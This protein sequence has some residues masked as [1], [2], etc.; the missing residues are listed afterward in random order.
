M[1]ATAVLSAQYAGTLE[2]LDST[3]VDARATQPAPTLTA[4]LREI[5]LAADASTSPTARLRLRDRWWDYALS[6]S[7]SFGVTDVELGAGAQP[8]VSNAGTATIA[9]HDRVV[10]VTV[11]ESASYGLENLAYLYAATGQGLAGGT[12]QSMGG[13][14]PG[15]PATMVPGQP[16][17]ATAAG[18]PATAAAMSAATATSATPLKLFPFGS[19]NTN[20][21]V[22]VR[23]TR[24]VTLSL[25]GGYSLAGSLTTNPQAEVA[26]PEQ[27][28]PLGSASLAYALSKSDS[29][30]TTASAQETTTPLGACVPLPPPTVIRF[31]RQVVPIIQGQEIARHQLSTTATVSAGAGVAASIQDLATEEA[32][33]IMPT[34][35]L[36]FTERVGAIDN[37]NASTLLLSAQLA[38]AVD[39]NSAQLRNG[40]QTTAMLT[41]PVARTVFL[42]FTAGVLQ[43]I[44][45]DPTPLT[46]LSG[47]ID[48]R[49]RVTRQI[50]VS[51]GVQG[52]WQKQAIYG[53]AAVMAATAAEG[54]VPPTGPTTT[55]SEIGYVALTAR[56]PTLRF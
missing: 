19:S 45:P 39:I 30:I 1:I 40:V 43:S 52:F 14:T 17:A 4:P 28:G 22:V 54:T 16:P 41:N 5:V 48:M 6:Y 38:P 55:A 29:L 2:L 7:P 20:A 25:S 31:C 9:W 51:L 18:Q 32:W 46:A 47:G 11:S 56:V 26:L 15:Q 3:K 53:A 12:G 37:R 27:F 49:F 21:T 34:G 24:Q 50:D 35:V 23:A 44:P 33:V 13:T 42:S 36:S 8:V 10:R